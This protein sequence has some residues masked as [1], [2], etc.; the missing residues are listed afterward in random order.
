MS[1]QLSEAEQKARDKRGGLTR[2][3][4]NAANSKFANHRPKSENG[5]F[6]VVALYNDNPA[7]QT[8]PFPNEASALARFDTLRKNPD[9][10][11]L[12]VVKNEVIY[13]ADGRPSGMRQVTLYS[14]HRSGQ[15]FANSRVETLYRRQGGND[16]FGMK[17][18]LSTPDL[19]ALAL[20]G[21][22]EV[23]KKIIRGGTPWWASRA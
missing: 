2:R 12:R 8:A 1:R 16:V 18:I 3:Q 22:L 23:A 11:Y 17:H 4:Y 20:V 19:T 5:S 21:Q 6:E 10:Y 9:A 15:E 14:L 13:G 7:P